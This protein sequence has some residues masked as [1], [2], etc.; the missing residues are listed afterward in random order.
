MGFA[1]DN[2]W[3]SSNM[4]SWH[5]ETSSDHCPVVWTN[6]CYDILHVGHVSLFEKCRFFASTCNARFIIGIDSDK[7]VKAMKGSSRPINTEEDRAKVLLNIRGVDS[8][9]AYD[10]D[11]E[12]SDVIK[13]FSPIVMVIGDDYIDRAVIGSEYAKSV[14]YF[15]KINGYSTSEIVNAARK[16]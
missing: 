11:G 15:P 12:L 1:V 8:V 2:I 16:I 4:R 3:Q 14:F 10:T 13:K 5:N 9:W 6:G 7:R